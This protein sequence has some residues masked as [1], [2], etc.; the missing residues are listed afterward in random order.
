[1]KYEISWLN[2][3]SSELEDIRSYIEQFDP[4]AAQ[5]LVNQIL[6]H[7][8]KLEELPYL[9]QLDDVVPELR[10]IVVKPNYSVYYQVEEEKQTVF[11]AHVWHSARDKRSI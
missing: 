8:R 2:Q 5:K 1:M 9:G 10:F 3:A 11:I 6:K 7:V 4:I